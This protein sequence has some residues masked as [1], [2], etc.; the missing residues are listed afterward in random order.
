MAT[1]AIIVLRSTTNIFPT[2]WEVIPGEEWYSVFPRGRQSPNIY[3]HAIIM[4][5]NE[6]TVVV[7]L[8]APNIA[9]A[10][11]LQNFADV[12]ARAWTYSELIADSGV[13]ATQVKTTWRTQQSG[14]L[15]LPSTPWGFE[16]HNRFKND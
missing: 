5:E 11:W 12:S 14:S 4:A 10:S 13:A 3:L 2:N 6:T 7:L 9:M 8:C 1:N 16:Y 15:E